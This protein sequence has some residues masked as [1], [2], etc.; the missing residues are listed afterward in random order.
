MI[1][2]H[3]GTDPEDSIFVSHCTASKPQM[4]S[5][6]INKYNFLNYVLLIFMFIVIIFPFQI[7]HH[8]IQQSII[9]LA[10]SII[11]LLG[12]RF[13]SNM[14]CHYGIIII[15]IIIFVV[16]VII[17][18]NYIIQNRCINYASYSQIRFIYILH[19]MSFQSS[20]RLANTQL[21]AV[22]PFGSGAPQLVK[23]DESGTPL[24]SHMKVPST[25]S[26]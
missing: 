2:K 20:K 8:H 15:T 1:L 23:V 14:H 19:G 5:A 18:K 3:A 6:C 17:G 25:N 21:S 11:I 10:S 22:P 4:R 7:C 24:C 26:S 16:Y 9:S 13:V 12:K